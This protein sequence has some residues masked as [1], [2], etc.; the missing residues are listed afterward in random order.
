MFRSAKQPAPTDATKDQRPLQAAQE[1]HLCNNS[2]HL[3]F[4]LAD[5]V[6]RRAVAQIIYLEDDAPLLSAFK[7]GLAR[8]YPDIAISYSTDADQIVAFSG[9]PVTGV[10]R[11]NLRLG[12]PL[13]IT[14]ATRWA[15]PLLSGQRFK[16]GYIY[17]PGLFTAKPAAF[18]CA[19]VVMRESGLNNY[20]TFRARG[21]KAVIRALSGLPSTRQV[22]GEERWIDVIEVSQPQRLPASVRQKAHSLSFA[23]ILA[24]LSVAQ[25]AVLGCIFVPAPPKLRDQATQRA[26]LLTQPLDMIGLCSAADKLLIYQT[27]V[28]VLYQQG[29][30]VYVKFH[31]LEAAYAI[32]DASYFDVDFPVELWAAI[33]LPRFDLAVALCSASLTEGEAL[34][35][36]KAVQ[37]IEAQLFNAAGFAHWQADLPAGLDVLKH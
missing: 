33:G 15:L 26:V 5:I 1:L 12:G 3:L 25:S 31:P 16:T 10:L 30:D 36:D 4:A 14:R 21:S 29:Y 32:S 6:S 23:S 9:L 8:A 11:R 24:K 22:W 2:R 17:H 19:H 37:L 34:I 18:A 27:I 35:A 28:K 7:A 13:G 20:V